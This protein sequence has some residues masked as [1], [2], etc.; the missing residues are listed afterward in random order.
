MLIS[1]TSCYS[2]YLL[3]SADLKPDG[4]TVQCVKCGNQWYQD[5]TIIKNDLIGE[6]INTSTPAT[7]SQNQKNN[8]KS[9]T[10]NLPSTYVKEQK[11]SILNSILVVLFVIIFISGFWIT[12]NL[13]IN[14]L[15][16]FKFYLDE[17]TFNLKLIFNDIAKIIHQIL[18]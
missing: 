6:V 16:L 2:K 11:V 9:P 15:V 3:N 5:P 17:F 1:C 4:R 14:S 18:N 10:P 8:L 12:R 7:S 13:E